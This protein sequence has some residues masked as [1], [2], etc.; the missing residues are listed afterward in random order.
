MINF[1]LIKFLF[2]FS[3]IF[4]IFSN[5]LFAEEKTIFKTDPYTF[6]SNDGYYIFKIFISKKM[7]N[8]EIYYEIYFNI[9][10]KTFLNLKNSRILIKADNKELKLKYIKKSYK[11]WFDNENGLWN[12][13]LLLKCSY[14]DFEFYLKSE[15]SFLLI[16]TENNIIKSQIPKDIKTSV[17]SFINYVK[18]IGLDFEK[19]YKP[20]IYLS[21]SNFTL[22]FISIFSGIFFDYGIDIN[23]NLHFYNTLLLI[24]LYSSYYSF[25][26][27]LPIKFLIFSSLDLSFFFIQYPLINNIGKIFLFDLS[28]IFIGTTINLFTLFKFINFS[29]SF[30]PGIFL[31]LIYDENENILSPPFNINIFSKV[32]AVQF[33]ANMNFLIS[34]NFILSFIFNTRINLSGIILYCIDLQTKIGF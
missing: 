9:Q 23:S 30:A 29:L 16:K 15:N 10:S 26:I 28:G 17:K 25:Q 8:D 13:E 7:F 1:K 12:E 32:I 5:N 4:I 3:I 14:D 2:I 6:N 24:N 34:N 33:S 20:F 18:E 22:P 11:N 31:A 27:Y 19:Q 21:F